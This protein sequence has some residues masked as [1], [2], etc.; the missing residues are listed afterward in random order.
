[1]LISFHLAHPSAGAV[2]ASLVVKHVSHIDVQDCGTLAETDTSA[3][4]RLFVSLHLFFADQIFPALESHSD[5][6]HCMNSLKNDGL[7]R[8][9]ITFPDHPRPLLRFG[10]DECGKLLRRAAHRVRTQA[11]EFFA[12][13]RRLRRLRRLP[14]EAHHDLVRRAGPHAERD[15]KS[16][17]LN[18]SHS[19]IS[20]AVFCLKKKKKKKLTQIYNVNNNLSNTDIVNTD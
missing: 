4:L 20:Y 9:H 11:R 2:G 17:R 15:R 7:L 8:L 13:V 10:L 5:D 16:T 14:V 1:M 18:S 12:N 19:Q 6:L 3:E